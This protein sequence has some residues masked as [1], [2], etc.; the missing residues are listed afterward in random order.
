MCWLLGSHLGGVPGAAALLLAVGSHLALSL[1]AAIGT[2][3]VQPD[4]HEFHLQAVD[5]AAGL[6]VLDVS[7][8]S[9]LFWTYAIS[10]LYTPFGPSE[11]LG[12]VANQWIFLAAVLQLGKFADETGVG[13]H[14]WKI[15]VA[16]A[17]MPASLLNCNFLLRESLQVFL[18]IFAVRHLEIYRREGA[19]KSLLLAGLAFVPFG[20]IH[21][22][23]FLFSP[24][25]IAGAVVARL[26]SLP[27]AGQAGRRSVGFNAASLVLG[28]IVLALAV[29]LIGSVNEA[30]RL[31]QII[32]GDVDVG[33]SIVRA[34][35]RGARTAF[36]WTAPPGVEATAT[37]LPILLVQFLYAPIV[38]FMI[39][40]PEDLVAGLD[41]LARIIFLLASLEYFRRGTAT[42]RRSTLFLLWLYL[43]FCLVAAVGTTTVGTALRHHL[44]VFWVIIALGAPVLFRSSDKGAPR[45]ATNTRSGSLTH[46]LAATANRRLP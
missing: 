17:L 30:R 26:L 33:E 42:Q 20:A 29:G 27:R 24:I 23:F 31:D 32:E 39:Q 13:A 36:L 8:P 25:A 11:W 9:S 18:L 34:G 12:Y 21:N 43:A 37:S 19:S 35:E 1:A 45:P 22:G 41:A 10:L 40:E 6:R 7:G 28:S 5:F 46:S 38:P 14:K 4:S 16:F 2:F 44:K 15:V 3:A